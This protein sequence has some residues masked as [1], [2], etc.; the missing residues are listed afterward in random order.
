MF[1]FTLDEI[2]KLR[3]KSKNKPSIIDSLEEE[4]QDLLRN[5]ILIPE[6]ALATWNLYYFCPKHSVRLKFDITKMYQ[7]ECPV[8]GEIFSGVPYDG[9]WWVAVNETNG[10]GCYILG[11]LWMLTENVKYLNKAKTILTEYAK[12]YPGYEVH[13][14]IPHNKPGKAFSQTM[15]D[16]QWVRFLA[17]GYD[18]IHDSLTIE[19]QML[20]EEN[21]LAVSGEFLKKNRLKQTHNHEVLISISVAMIGMLINR[22]DMIDFAIYEKYGLIYQLENAF[23]SDGLW[24]EGSIHY[25]IYVMEMLTY[26]GKFF[27]DT[28]HSLVDHPNYR[29]MFEYILN[30]I[31]PDN[32]IPRINDDLL[33]YWLKDTAGFYELAYGTYGDRRYAWLLNKCYEVS[34][35][36]SLDAFFYG[37]DEIPIVEDFNMSDYHNADG[38]GITVFRGTDKRYLLVKHSPYGGEHDHYDRLGLS[39]MAFGKNVAADFG[40]TGYGAKLH[41]DY[42][43]NSGSHNTVVINE[44]NQPPANP[45]VLAYKRG[46]DGILL[47]AEV[48]WDGSCDVPDCH[49][50]VEWDVESY[51]NVSMRRIILWCDDYFIEVFKVQGVPDKTI[52]WILHVSGELQEAHDMVDLQG[53]FSE[54]K[55][56]KYLKDIK[57][58]KPEKIH[59]SSWKVNDFN[60]NL[61]SYCCGDNRIYYGK[62]PDNPSIKDVSY[63]INRIEG[64]EAIF[65]NVF[66]AYGEG[67]S[68]IEDVI[69]DIKDNNCEVSVSKQDN[70]KKHVISFN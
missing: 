7:H 23:L 41:Y 30:V 26:Y 8:D 15:S 44:E 14:D 48:R 40:T 49:T 12:Y 58:L 64:K 20:I 21:L 46:T 13:G 6:T 42:Y 66:E 50:T 29:K 39:F 35:R 68:H 17:M 43:K 65:I 3:L 61:F 18:L 33:K 59:K 54:K 2:E 57:S 37:A 53:T 31:Q 47:D 11:L 56:L 62:G 19:E 36:N 9:A 25:Q 38:S 55:P 67:H 27:K 28:R 5:D 63:I 52:D 4:V 34:Q 10:R 60:F 22:K 45:K 69:I 24:F 32:E 1:Q 51:G 70:I 16:A